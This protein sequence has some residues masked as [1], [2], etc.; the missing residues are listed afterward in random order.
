MAGFGGTY[1]K[2]FAKISNMIW[3]WKESEMRF[4]RG[5]DG[6]VRFERLKEPESVR[7]DGHDGGSSVLPD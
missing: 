6:F 7:R 3:C 4:P 5:S 2:S 1:D